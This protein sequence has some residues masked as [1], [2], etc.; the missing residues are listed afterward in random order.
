MLSEFLNQCY[1][2]HQNWNIDIIQSLCVDFMIILCL[3]YDYNLNVS[4]WQKPG[5]YQC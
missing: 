5:R 3:F 1:S 2:I 4:A